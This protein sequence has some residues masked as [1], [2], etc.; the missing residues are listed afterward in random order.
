M[1]EL[2]IFSYAISKFIIMLS[3][4]FTG[5]NV[6]TLLR[7]NGDNLLLFGRNLGTDY[8]HL[9]WKIIITIWL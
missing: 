5:L 9:M 4:P 7:F 8:F 3:I 6:R 2:A 1:L